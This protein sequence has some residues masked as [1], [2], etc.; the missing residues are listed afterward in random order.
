M[1]QISNLFM[2]PSL[3]VIGEIERYMGWGGGEEGEFF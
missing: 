1:K 2:E 3:E